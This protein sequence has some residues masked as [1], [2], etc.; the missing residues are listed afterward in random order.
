MFI[1]SRVSGTVFLLLQRGV[2]FEEAG[3]GCSRITRFRVWGFSVWGLGI[4]VAF[5]ICL[6]AGTPVTLS[7]VVFAT[8]GTASKNMVLR[9]LYLKIQSNPWAVCCR[10][11]PEAH[12]KST[13][14]SRRASLYQF[15]WLQ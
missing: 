2:V 10:A 15:E 1:G 3:W 5:R 8:S 6:Q 13:N 9:P 11:P 14:K 12:C 4:Q 7:C